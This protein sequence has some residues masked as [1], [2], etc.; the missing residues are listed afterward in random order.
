MEKTKE[1]PIHKDT[2]SDL[3]CKRAI[4]FP[5]DVVFS[6]PELGQ[7]YSW[8]QVWNE[9]QLLGKGFLQLGIQKGDRVV[10]LMQGRIE[11]ILS[12]YAAASIGAVIVPLN[13]YSK[14]EELL[15]YLQ[16]SKP[17]LMIMGS[18]G[19]Q[20]YYPM[21][22]QELIA[23]TALDGTDSS[24][25]PPHM[26]VLNEG[27]FLQRPFRPFSD[28]YQLAAMMDEHVFRLAYQSIRAED[29][30]IL[31]YTSGTLGSPKGVLRS[32]AS[33]LV[34]KRGE[35]SG[36]KGSA[37]MAG[38][39]D[40]VAHKFSLFSLLPLYHLGGFAT[41]FTALKVCN[42][43]VV[44]LTHFNPVNAL[45]VLELE[46][47]QIM[48]GTPFM[49]QQMLTS[50]RRSEFDLSSLVGLA[51]TSA[52]INNTLLKKVSRDPGLKLV[53]FM[54]S[55]GSSEAGS[56]ANGIC[57]LNRRKNPLWSL[58]YLLLSYTSFLSGMIDPKELE[59][60]GFSFGG[61]VDKGVE[62]KIVNPETGEDLPQHAHG[63][64]A[65][66]SHRVMRYMKENTV[67]PC[68]TEDGWYRSGDSGF[69]DEQRNLMITGRLNR[70]ISRG[71]EKI[72]PVEIE[73]L[74]VKQ[75][76]VEEAFVVGIPDELYGELICACIIPEKGASLTE[77]RLKAELTP[78]MSAFK[79]PRY[80]LFLPS[81]PLSATG[82][83]SVSEIQLL[84][85]ERIGELKKNA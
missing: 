85:L 56:V 35:K 48:T 66:R 46:K 70:L 12:M 26:F 4:T 61:K 5:H 58:L 50:S 44:M 10:L 67:S 22:I 43:R 34:K 69:L 54:V 60:G 17:A 11:L 37:L 45:S 64:I 28:I 27:T 33:F 76:G 16:D 83:I 68:F 21:M 2:L 84:A 29:P 7:H 77:E 32:T 6:F 75:K 41:L 73:N 18:G 55:Y 65:I 39:T 79:I 59:R 63:E 57:F 1:S 80:I 74:L 47:C 53:F 9:V 23:E 19:H 24:W 8:S 38:L 42:I 13:A 31:L 30:L 72:S 15:T 3:L 40:R 25:L 82:K 49:I 62:V 81:F 14:K 52:A 51:F 36:K 78:H 20:Q 71:G